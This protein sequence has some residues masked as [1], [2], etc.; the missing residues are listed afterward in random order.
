MGLGFSTFPGA[1]GGSGVAVGSD[2]TQIGCKVAGS[3]RRGPWAALRV[4]RAP[5][6]PFRSMLLV[7]VLAALLAGGSPARAQV[8]TQVGTAGTGSL[9]QPVAPAL[10][11]TTL[12]TPLSPLSVGEAAVV[13]PLWT[14][15]PRI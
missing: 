9:G 12:V 11:S 4:V 10:P 3:S 5:F 7:P 6:A 1:D 8:S 15:S 14:F 13:R 2:G